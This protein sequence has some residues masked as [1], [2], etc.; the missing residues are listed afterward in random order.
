MFRF[1]LLALLA[2]TAFVGL[3]CAALACATPLVANITLFAVVLLL[4]SALVAA[5]YAARPLRMFA[6]GFAMCGW[7]YFLIAEG[8]LSGTLRLGLVR[9]Q[10][11]WFNCDA[12]LRRP[13][14]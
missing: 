10:A 14:H 12:C 3:G 9:L 7:V 5:T 1:S 4:S 8:W 6:G 2:F 13:K 11:T